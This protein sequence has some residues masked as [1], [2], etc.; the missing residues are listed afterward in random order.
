M[1]MIYSM[2]DDFIV[3]KVLKILQCL[4]STHSDSHTSVSSH[5]KTKIPCAFVV[6]DLCMHILLI[7][8]HAACEMSG[9]RRLR[10]TI[11]F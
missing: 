8:A 6:T 2:D 1:L 3:D 9:S 5:A 4:A 11:H 7:S 10:I